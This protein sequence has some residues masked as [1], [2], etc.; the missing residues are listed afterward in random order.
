MT[1]GFGDMDVTLATAMRARADVTM[2]A[3]LCRAVLNDILA[4]DA[5]TRRREVT[6]LVAA[7][8][9]G[10][11]R[12]LATATSAARIET[13]VARFADAR[14]LAPDAARWAVETWSAAL[15]TT[16]DS[17]IAAASEPERPSAAGVATAATIRPPAPARPVGEPAAEPVGPLLPT[18]LPPQPV[19]KRW[20]RRT[21]A[22]AGVA[23]V[24]LVALVSGVVAFAANGSNGPDK[25]ASVTT[26]TPATVAPT[27]P[28][29]AHLNPK[30]VTPPALSIS[31]P[32]SGA[33]VSSSHL[34]VVGRVETG[35][36][37]VFVGRAHKATGPF[38]G[39]TPVTVKNG[40]WSFDV[41]L[42]A[43]VTYLE[44]RANDASK[45]TNAKVFS[46]VYTP[47][48]PP[49][50]TVPPT[51][52]PTTP[53]TSPPT[54]PPTNPPTTPTTHATVHCADGTVVSSIGDC[55]L[56]IRFYG[57]TSCA[58]G[59]T[60]HYTADVDN[61]TSRT[62][63]TWSLHCGSGTAAWPGSFYVT[64]NKSGTCDIYLTVN[65]PNGPRT[66]TWYY[67]ITIP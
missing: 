67:R 31:V 48:P 63:G 57:P 42:A 18:V 52:P 61:K 44:F 12:T 10:V 60:C 33:H 43:G 38:K 27:T 9:E 34:H 22:F 7:V 24:G 28:T 19:T 29:T 54:T 3:D 37:L 16:T 59:T 41:S 53:H 20:S 25:A 35:A 11:P 23:V 17:P 6:L 5:T 51:S 4:A 40:R 13:I 62:T 55:A 15:R 64:P 8:E 26:Q 32:H 21:G 65:D 49:V 39:I 30:D 66:K 45:N 1:G 2:R 36:R 58:I 46:V 14:G 50:T 56:F 47:P